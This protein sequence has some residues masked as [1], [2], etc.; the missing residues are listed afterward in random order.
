MG[1]RVPEPLD[2]NNVKKVA[3][4]LRPSM[5]HPASAEGRDSSTDETP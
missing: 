2:F 1:A 4:G 5:R 3:A